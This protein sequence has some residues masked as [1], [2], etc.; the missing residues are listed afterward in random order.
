[1]DLAT[2]RLELRVVM[3]SQCNISALFQIFDLRLGFALVNADRRNLA[4]MYMSFDVKGFAQGYQEMLLVQLRVSLYGI[5]LD[6]CGDVAKFC[7]RQL[8]ELLIGVWHGL[9]SPFSAPAACG[10]AA[11]IS[12]WVIV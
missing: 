3:G 10:C 11:G 2:D 12:R 9:D 5:V 7:Y 8:F 4:M 6:A 1:M